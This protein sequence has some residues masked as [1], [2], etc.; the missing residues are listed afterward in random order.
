MEIPVT[1]VTE[2]DNGLR[3]ASVET[4]GWVCTFGMVSNCGSRLEDETN[5][6]V[7]H[8]MELLVYNGTTGEGSMNASSFTNRMD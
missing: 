6:G 5:T 4:Y 1:K 2:L 8:L 3:V 7:N